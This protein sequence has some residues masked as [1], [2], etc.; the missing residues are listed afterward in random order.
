[1]SPSRLPVAVALWGLCGSAGAAEFDITP[2]DAVEL[3]P[4]GIEVPL[5]EPEVAAIDAGDC[6]DPGSVVRVRGRAFEPQEGREAVLAGHGIS[7]VLHVL[8]WTDSRIVARLPEDG[9]LEAGKRYYIG[10]RDAADSQWL[11]N[12]D[13][14]L[15]TCSSVAEPGTIPEAPTV[16]DEANFEPPAEARES[17]ETARPQ[18]RN[19]FGS[20]GGRITRYQPPALVQGD[21]GTDRA[22][23]RA[24]EVEPGEVL[25]W[26]ASLEAAQRFAKRVRPAGYQVTRRQ[27][28][29]GLGVVQSTLR[30]PEDVSPATALEQ[31]RN[32]F[33][34]LVTDANHRFRPLDADEATALVGWS[35]QRVACGAGVTIGVID[36]GVDL[37]VL[38]GVGASV[39]VETVPPAGTRPAPTDHGTAVTARI[40]QLVPESRLRV[41]AVFRDRGEDALDTTAEWLVL[42]LDWLARQ[43]PAAINLSLGGPYN[44]LLARAL[45]RLRR[46]GIGLVAA[47]AEHDGTVLYPG[48]DR[49]VLGVV[50]V[51]R[52]LRP[53]RGAHRGDAVTFTAPGVDVRVPGIERYLSGASHAAPF[54]TAALALARDPRLLARSARDLGDPGRDPVFGFGL[55][56]FAET[57]QR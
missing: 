54:V 10:I 42:G 11:S 51:D 14:S 12:I 49:N 27:V 45:A 44:R 17:G 41:A 29:R 9:G 31:L 19:P 37:E 40:A 53:E 8:E 46:Q 43:R 22:P 1:M 47:L 20:S 6:A 52:E 55:V 32:A 23:T 33:P 39:Q 2:P 4:A 13:R 7:R 56:R 28:L 36:S 48:S 35:P 16:D 3:P 26:H 34:D 15:R 25:L 50:A 21:D 57:C 24:D 5:A 18:P 38:E 30:I